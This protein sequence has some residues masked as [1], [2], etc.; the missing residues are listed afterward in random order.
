[1]LIPSPRRACDDGLFRVKIHSRQNQIDKSAARAALFLRQKEE[2]E[3][4]KATDASGRKQSRAELYFL[5]GGD[6][7]WNE[8]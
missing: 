1:M 5:C 7:A 6:I 2:Q 3:E 4:R 8:H